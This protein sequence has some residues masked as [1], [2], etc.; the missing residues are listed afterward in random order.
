MPGVSLILHS[1]SHFLKHISNLNVYLFG[2]QFRY[3]VLSLDDEDPIRRSCR[4]FDQTLKWSCRYFVLSEA[5]VKQ[6]QSVYFTQRKMKQTKF[7]F[8]Y[9]NLSK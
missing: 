2:Q 8:F 1:M 3:K 7:V 5:E 9:F 4:K 6:N